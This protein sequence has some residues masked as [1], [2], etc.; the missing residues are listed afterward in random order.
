ME[1]RPVILPQRSNAQL[2]LSGREKPERLEAHIRESKSIAVIENSEVLAPIEPH[3]H[4]FRIGDKIV[5]ECAK[6]LCGGELGLDSGC[7]VVLSYLSCQ[8]Q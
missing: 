6:Q 7:P 5:D 2:E 1:F 4:L 8:I 3:I